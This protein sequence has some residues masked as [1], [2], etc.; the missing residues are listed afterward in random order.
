MKKF[1]T[2]I[3]IVMGT[4]FLVSCNNDELVQ[5]PVSTVSKQG[6][7][8]D[9]SLNLGEQ[10][11][12][13]IGNIHNEALKYVF[14]DE[15]IK[16]LIDDPNR[17]D[18]IA[19]QKIKEKLYE[20][21]SKANTNVD[22]SALDKFIY[23]EYFNNFESYKVMVNDNNAKDQE[24]LLVKNVLEKSESLDSF[25]ASMQNLLDN[26]DDKEFDKTK[27]LLCAEITKKS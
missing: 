26:L 15:S 3:L 6:K 8:V 4:Y 22:K 27:I 13:S 11:I 12:I 17:D 16:K 21:F 20:Y 19:F 9:N 23:S 25:S 24:V 1:L 2:C 18:E 5:E 10:E 14:S 7:L